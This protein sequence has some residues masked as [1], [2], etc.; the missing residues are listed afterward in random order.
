MRHNRP[1]KAVARK[2]LKVIYSI[3]KEPRPYEERPAALGRRPQGLE[4]CPPR[5]AGGACRAHAT[6]ALKI[7]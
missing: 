1:L 5:R 2:R 6:A 7:T 3:M 4:A